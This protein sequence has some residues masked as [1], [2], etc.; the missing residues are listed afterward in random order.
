MDLY[1]GTGPSGANIRVLNFSPPTII[2]ENLTN[3]KKS[4]RK[5]LPAAKA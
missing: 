3:I 4:G 1:Q 2:S 5:L